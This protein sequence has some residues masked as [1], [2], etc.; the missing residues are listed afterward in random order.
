MNTNLDHLK[1]LIVWILLLNVNTLFAANN[2][3]VDQF[4]YL[5]N[6]K[7]IAVIS[8]SNTGKFSPDAYTPGNT[9][10]VRKL[11]DNTSVF[12]GS[13]KAWNKG[14]LDKISGDKVWYFDFSTMTTEGEY[15]IYDVDNSKK[16]YTFKI[17][18][19]V[20][21]DILKAATRMFYYQRRSTDKPA[22]YAGADWA[23]GLAFLNPNQDAACML[24]GS[25]DVK[26]KRDLRGGW[27]DAGDY[28]QYVTFTIS[29]LT[30]MLFAYQNNP[31]I[32]GDNNNIPESG[33]GIP[34]LLDEIKWE[35]DWLLRMQD[36]DGS[37]F[38]VKGEPAN[39]PG[40]LFPPSA[41]KKEQRY[42]PATTAASFA[43][44][45]VL[46]LAS[47][48]YGSIQQTSYALTLKTASVNAYKW[49]DAHPGVKFFNT[50]KL[51]AGENQKDDNG[52]IK[53]KI[54]ASIYLFDLTNETSYTPY[55]DSNLST[56]TW[57]SMFET[58]INDAWI[59]YSKANAA[60]SSVVSQIN[61]GYID[62]VAT[63]SDYL[64]S[65]N[66]G[67]DAYRSFLREENYTWGSNKTKSAVGNTILALTQYGIKPDSTTDYDAAQGYLNY[68][69]GVNAL[70]L[71]F[72]TNMS[73]L[74]AENSTSQIYH[75]WFGQGTPWSTNVP[76]GYIPGGPDKDY[77]FDACCPSGCGGSNPL[78]SNALAS[79]A[80]GQPAQK[81]YAN[82]NDNWPVNSWQIT[83]PAIYYQAAYVRLIS[84]FV[85][86]NASL[87][88]P[89]D[90]LKYTNS[91]G[92]VNSKNINRFLFPNPTSGLVEINIPGREIVAL[93]IFDLSGVKLA[94]NIC[95]YDNSIT[96]DLSS[97]QSGNYFIVVVDGKQSEY[98]K[99]IKI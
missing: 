72:L 93:S 58:E 81:C 80:I 18:K 51:C 39:I 1:T 57:V 96:V 7:K 95:R 56:W 23:D 99:V 11:S 38:C 19:N 16:S 24:Y 85:N 79:S 97:L 4:G 75:S 25:N 30:D 67:A 61:S 94:A 48:V 27:F 31:K 86:T 17:A 63:N 20:Y 64:A 69:H 78:C 45:A 54:M 36:T 53:L 91:V 84:A 8:Q 37:I 76:P 62:G 26:T 60:T 47:K 29:V 50:A 34:D 77:A 87:T 13:A 68:M 52:V 12:S 32:W 98:F 82:I 6:A 35:L 59:T 71:C 28:N 83:E 89:K 33:N 22:T 21:D 9:F 44:S 90:V 5:P 74:G 41:Y 2:I 10:E 88:I 46:A 14:A 15:Y 3:K 70:D 55:I 65:Y 92:I 42:G 66:S 43:A 73:S 49:A 40:T